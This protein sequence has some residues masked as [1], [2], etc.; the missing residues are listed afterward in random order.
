M[1]VSC[2]WEKGHCAQAPSPH[3]RVIPCPCLIEPFLPV[4]SPPPSQSHQKGS[5]VNGPLC[6]PRWP[7]L[8]TALALT[9]SLV[10]RNKPEGRQPSPALELPR[11][12]TAKNWYGLVS[13]CRARESQQ[14][15]PGHLSAES[16]AGTMAIQQLQHPQRQGLVPVVTP[17]HYCQVSLPVFLC[18]GSLTDPGSIWPGLFRVCI[19][20]VVFSFGS[21][22]FDLQRM[23][24]YVCLPCCELP[25]RRACYVFLYLQCLG[26]C[27]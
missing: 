22:C 1:Q 10:S 23:Y 26:A 27:K 13:I 7:C 8:H 25:Q 5:A 16:D 9:T 19:S 20:P 11:G 2:A 17:V 21:I 18:T 12:E 4:P 6:A 14:L 24:M 3:S 15:H